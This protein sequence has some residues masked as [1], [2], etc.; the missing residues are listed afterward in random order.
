VLGV[1]LL[2]TAIADS[3]ATECTLGYVTQGNLAELTAISTSGTPTRV[4][5]GPGDVGGLSVSNDGSTAYATGR[6]FF[7]GTAELVA[8][9]VATGDMV[10]VTTNLSQPARLVVNDAETIAYVRDGT[11][12]KAV[13]LATGAVTTLASGLSGSGGL[14]VNA[15]ETTAYVGRTSTPTAVQAVDLATGVMAEIAAVSSPTDLALDAAES[16]LYVISSSS[17][18]LLSVDLGSGTVTTIATGI[19]PSP[20]DPV[21]LAVDAAE[22]TAFMALSHPD[23]SAFAPR[24]SVSLTTGAVTYAGDGPAGVIKGFT[25]NSAETTVFAI[26]AWGDLFAIDV[27]SGAVSYVHDSFLGANRV[28]LSP[29]GG[30]AY[31]T[32][33]SGHRLTAVDLATGDMTLVATPIPFAEGVAL[34]AD[35]TTAYVTHG[36]FADPNNGVLSAVDLATG[37]KVVVAAGLDDPRGLTVNAASTIAYVVENSPPFPSMGRLSAV[38]LTTGAVT[39]IAS[40]GLTR[41]EAVALH[42]TETVA[43]V[44]EGTSGELSVVDLAAGG[45]FLVA[46]LDGPIDVALDSTGYTAYVTSWSGELLSV[47][48]ATGIV[49]L[50]SDLDSPVG[51]ALH[52]S[53]VVAASITPSNPMPGTGSTIAACVEIDV[54]ETARALGSYGATLEWDPDVLTYVGFTGGASPFGSPVVNAAA[55]ATGSLTFADADPAGSCGSSHV[56]C[57]EFDVPGA[58]GSSSPLDLTLT[59]LFA[60]TTFDDMLP[61]VAVHDATIDVPLICLMGNVNAGMSVNSGDA[62]IMLA[63]DVGLPIPPASAALIASM[64]G[65]V[66]GDGLTNATDANI[67]LSYEVGLPIDPAY[68]VGEAVSVAPTFDSCPVCTGPEPPA[69]PPSAQFASEALDPGGEV[70]ARIVSSRQRVREGQEFEVTITVD[71]DAEGLDLGSYAARLAWQPNAMEFLGIAEGETVGF[72]PPVVNAGNAAG[73]ELRLAAASPL[74]ANGSV[75]LLHLRF[76]ALQP[77]LHPAA[78][79]D[80]SF[81]SLA[82][83]GPGFENLLPLLHGG[84]GSVS[85]GSR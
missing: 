26:Q 55:A 17:G 76:R 43:Y 51:L 11:T 24:V 63:H 64:C 83:R 82:A 9:D 69:P 62:L 56:L 66:N 45:V 75:A 52:T 47:D 2:L 79:L 34:D 14:A 27:S 29:D 21:G 38:D 80:L 53:G 35:G 71:V 50:A 7:A 37:A 36:D 67:V 16:T 58:G 84:L 41:P 44:T 78:A 30:T 73:G 42:A 4:A 13:D 25:M 72:E 59:S 46:S 40:A 33:Y 68:T 1:A 32:E 54:S 10:T 57:V 23:P 48:L 18:T 81:T 6:N 28:A 85:G 8:I 74:G 5:G 70:A 61:Q 65:D 60:A 15:A 22:T 3:A 39:V 49:S 20:F 77:L 19:G 31:V 12:L